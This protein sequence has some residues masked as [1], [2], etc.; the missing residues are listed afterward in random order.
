MLHNTFGCWHLLRL[1]DTTYEIGFL[2]IRFESTPNI[3]CLFLKSLDV[4]D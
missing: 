1:C 3:V 2:H 4:S